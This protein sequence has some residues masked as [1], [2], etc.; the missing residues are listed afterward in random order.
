MAPH[1]PLP[2]PLHLPDVGDL[3]VAEVLEH[4]VEQDLA[5]LVPARVP[6]ERGVLERDRA[7]GQDQAV[8]HGD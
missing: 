2:D 4:R 3:A 5:E 8:E 7:E 6:A 1:S